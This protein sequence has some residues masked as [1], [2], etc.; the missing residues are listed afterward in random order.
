MVHRNWEK[1]LWSNFQ[2]LRKVC[3]QP[4]PSILLEKKGKLVRGK[5]YVNLNWITVET[6][7]CLWQIFFDFHPHTN[8]HIKNTDSFTVHSFIKFRC[9]GTISFINTPNGIILHI[10][11]YKLISFLYTLFWLLNLIK[12]FQRMNIF[13]YSTINYDFQL[14]SCFFCSYFTVT[15]QQSE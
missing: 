4:H 11:F 7:L 12:H 6:F 9:F 15:K 8:T 14:N 2:L 1:E 10:N 3:L 5:R 13:C